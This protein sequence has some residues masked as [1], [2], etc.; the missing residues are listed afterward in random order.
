MCLILSFITDKIDEKVTP[1]TEYT[2][3]KHTTIEEKYFAPVIQGMNLAYT[4][5]T[6]R[7]TKIDSIN[8]AA[9]TGTAENYTRINGVRMK[10]TDHSIFVAFAPIEDPK[11]VV[12]VF[13]ENGSFGARIAGPV[14][15]LI[16]EKYLKGEVKRKELEKQMLE[17]SLEEEY[18]RPYKLLKNKVVAKTE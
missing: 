5:G 4:D 17:K 6:A 3:P 14:T 13:V 2:T 10:L 11:I 9:K 12:A 1:F 7:G 15:S 16:I 18:E 8:I